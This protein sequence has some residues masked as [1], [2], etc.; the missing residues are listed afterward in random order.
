MSD[1][2]PQNLLELSQDKQLILNQIIERL[3][4]DRTYLQESPKLIFGSVELMKEQANK[5]IDIENQLMHINYKVIAEIKKLESRNIVENVV[6]NVVD[7]V[8]NTVDRT[9]KFATGLGKFALGFKLKVVTMPIPVISNVAS[10]IGQN[11][12]GDGVD[13][14]VNA[15][16][17]KSKKESKKSLEL[18]VLLFLI[19][20]INLLISEN[21]KVKSLAE[22]CLKNPKLRKQLEKKQLRK[23]FLKKNLTLIILLTFA[24][25][26]SLNAIVSELRR[27]QY[28]PIVA[29]K[30]IDTNNNESEAIENTNILSQS[31]D[32]QK[33]VV[34]N[35]ETT[36]K[37][38]ENPNVND[39]LL[40]DNLKLEAAQKKAMEAS[41][42]AQNPPHS[43][44]V[45]Q[46]VE[47]KWQEAIDLLEVIPPNSPIYI[48]VKDKLTA[49]QQNH[50]IISQRILIEQKA[51]DN[52]KTAQELAYEAAVIV[53]KPYS[54]E[55]WLKA[56]SKLKQS[57]NLLSLIPQGT[58]VES[59]AKEKRITYQANYAVISS[60]LKS[61]KK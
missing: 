39:E 9:G 50:S 16:F 42:I 31:F 61:Y 59:I 14:M 35:I 1:V 5:L 23:E 52:L 57:I 32:N 12:L 2:K 54:I 40:S 22:E 27:I 30:N 44:E 11:L 53:Q 25:F 18:S 56:Q 43:L 20:T 7:N 49:Y 8:S 28:Q 17:D 58:F 6:V 24:S 26:I 4:I 51:A 19:K 36:N 21:S 15:L 37:I 41:I 10:E 3:Q 55:I 45:W 13:N 29:T 46:Q 38:S 34:S 48:K 60:K 47:S 33:Q